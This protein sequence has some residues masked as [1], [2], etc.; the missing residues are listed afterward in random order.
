M[1]KLMWFSIG[2]FSA[3][4]VGAYLISNVW[5]LIG[6]ALLLILGVALLV[7]KVKL[8]KIL[9]TV[10]VGTVVGAAWFLLFY[11]QQIN[12]LIPYDG[13]TVSA[14]AT[15]T[16]YSYEADFGIAAD[17]RVDIAGRSYKARIYLV[18]LDGLKPGDQIIGNFK[19]RMTTENSPKGATYHQGNGIFLLAYAD[20][21]VT[22]NQAEKQ[23]LRYLPAMLRKHITDTLD[24][25]F[26]EDTLAF[27]R[28]LLLGD[29]SLLSYETDT[30][31]KISGIR[32]VIAVSGLHVSILFSL[33]Y[34]LS[35]KR[36]AMTALLGIPVLA[37]FAAVA[38]FTPSIVRACIMQCLMILAL[39]FNR[40]YDPPTAL[41]FAVLVMLVINP[42]AVTS[43]SFQLS[44]GC[45][46]GILLFY[47]RF[48]GY[49]LRL[50][51]VQKGNGIKQ[52]LGRWFCG[53]AAITMSAM[54]VTTPLSA[55]YF[56]AVSI[57]GVITNLLTLWIISFVFYGVM[58]AWICGAIWLPAGRAVAWAISWPV[59]YVIGVA[60]L[61][62]K[63]P[64]SAV[65]TCSS[66]IV[67][68]L[69][70]CY[71]LFALLL[72]SK[73]KRV[74]ISN[75]CALTGLV[76]ALFLSALEPRLDDFR[77]TAF[78]VGQGQCLLI[79]SDGRNYLVDCGGDDAAG[80][81]DT[82]AAHLLS[83]G[84]SELD[85]LFLTH[86]DADHAEGAQLLLSRVTAEALYLP[87]IT[88][89]NSLRG[90]L[91]NTFADKITW[92]RQSGKI[93]AGDLIISLYPG[94]NPKDGNESS[95]CILFQHEKCD[96]LITGDRDVSGE[97]KLLQQVQL[98]DLEILV[99]GHHGSKNSTSL[100]LLSAT[101]PDIALISA[102]RDNRYGHPSQDVLHR[103]E[104]AKCKVFRT[105]LQG[106]IIFRR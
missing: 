17:G 41:S 87:D 15:I 45:L 96:I 7:F 65:Y 16:D 73:K 3:C 81:A 99:V 46:V 40:E 20:E 28:A 64:V 88:A 49:L 84:I 82:V 68:W 4:A 95:L 83:Q 2:F 93:I 77:V 51:K 85:G 60:K 67:I 21:N 18:N 59:R 66:Y 12:V 38:G 11:Q 10:G 94:Q 47:N 50:L 105:D 72:C 34:I 6:S 52:K 48:N 9:L 103:L 35:G 102:G 104:M 75:V 37:L 31:F 53:S 63:I 70:F 92:I 24:A 91:E 27:A 79:Q 5:L 98:P 58:L 19:I 44:V 97:R 90:K 1:R 26:P 106:T 13:Q 78:D 56:G 86:Y 55:W 89:D 23:E 29:S 61:I 30:A 74:I 57:F 100:E 25:V 62:S 54:I 36:R 69:I 80:T 43:V 22:L 76:A 101:K 42:L 32:H 33:V 39:L 8:G 14:T 71:L